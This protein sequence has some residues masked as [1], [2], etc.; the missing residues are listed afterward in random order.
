MNEFFDAIMEMHGAEEFK[1]LIRKWERLSSNTRKFPVDLPLLLPD[2]I[3][4]ASSGS[5]VTYLLQK[6]SDYLSVKENLISFYGDYKFF[7]F[8]LGYSSENEPFREIDRFN[9]CVS[10]AAGFRNEFR[11]I[12]RIDIDEFMGHQDEKYF[13]SF[14]EHLASNSDKWLIILTYAGGSEQDMKAMD[15]TIRSYMRVEKIR[16]EMP[17]SEEFTGYLEEIFGKCGLC[18]ADDGKVL[19]A[20]TVEKLRENKDFDGF[21][22]VRILGM[23]ILY[24]LLSGEG[25]FSECLTADT[26]RAFSAG[27]EYISKFIINLAKPRQIGFIGGAK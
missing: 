12:I 15:V 22:T 16:L 9:E 13:R 19:L 26:L 24:E 1:N 3:L 10:L 17:T 7:E 8:V 25:D 5:G 27:G 11:G 18:I 23:G 20:E 21:K 2:I 6:L 14:L 4:Q